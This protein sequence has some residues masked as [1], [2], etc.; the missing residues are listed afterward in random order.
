[1]HEKNAGLWQRLS[2]L[3]KKNEQLIRYLI[4]GG[5]TTALNYAV[6]AAVFLLIRGTPADYQ[7]ANA[8]AFVVAVAFAYFA[9]KKAVFFS[10][11]T[12]ARD[13]AREAG[14]FF[15]MRLISYGVEAGL[16]ALLVGVLRVGELVAKVPVNVVI[17]LL[18][19]VFSKLFI[20]R[21]PGKP[22]GAAE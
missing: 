19:Y 10:K 18:N 20:F 21:G 12:G 3:Y 13:T 16:M 15:L 14:S 11:T 5:L 22:E 8:A 2:E 6:Y 1:M 7:I 9:N 17:V 4:V